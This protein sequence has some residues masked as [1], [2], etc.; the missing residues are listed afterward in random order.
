MEP[1]Q[2]PVLL[3]DR[4]EGSIF[5]RKVLAEFRAFQ[6]LGEPYGFFRGTAPRIFGKAGQISGFSGF[7]AE[8][9]VKIPDL[10]CETGA[11]I[12]FGLGQLHIGGKLAVL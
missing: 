1:Q 4:P 10:F 3:I 6:L 8:I 7:I 11:F 2:I 12:S 9:I 5:F